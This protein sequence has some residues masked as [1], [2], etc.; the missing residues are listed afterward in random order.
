MTECLERKTVRGSMT[1]GLFLSGRGLNIYI[2]IYII[3]SIYKFRK[4]KRLILC[5]GI[6]K[7][8]RNS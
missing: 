2:Y 6:E 3:S 7:I 1:N 4:R 5:A 8:K